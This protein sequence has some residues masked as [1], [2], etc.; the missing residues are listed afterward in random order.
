VPTAA[1]EKW[2]YHLQHYRVHMRFMNDPTFEKLEPQA[3]EAFKDHVTATEM[4]MVEIAMKNP[5]YGMLV[6]Q[7]FPQ[8]PVFYVPEQIPTAPELPP[9]GG[10]MPPM[11][12]PPEAQPMPPEGMAAGEEMMMPPPEGMAAG[13]EAAAPMSPTLGE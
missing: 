11:G 7:E 1:P 9:M 4:F 6:A 3:K 12:M 8:F 5:Q 13:M 10:A 2:E